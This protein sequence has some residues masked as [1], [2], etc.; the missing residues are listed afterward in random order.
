MTQQNCIICGKQLPE[1]KRLRG[2]RTCSRSCATKLAFSDP[3]VRQAHKEALNT[4]EAK[5]KMS[6][7]VKRAFNTGAREKL[8]EAMKK[9]WQ[10]QEY[11]SKTYNAIVKGCRTESARLH[12]SEASKRVWLNK[13]YHDK[14]VKDMNST[15]SKQKFVTAMKL[16]YET[17]CR[18]EDYK[19]KMSAGVRN[20]F[21][22]RKDE[23]I[24]K[25]YN[26]KKKNNSFSASKQEELSGIILKEIYGSQNVLRQYKDIRYPYNCDFYITTKD[27][28]IECNFFWHHGK[29]FFDPSIQWQKEQYIKW[30]EKSKTSACYKAA[31]YTW[32]KRDLDKLACAKRNNLNYLAFFSIKDFLSYFAY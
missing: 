20:A 9:K 19:L 25:Q 6:E 8:S 11:R 4:K 30:L 29:D 1:N 31:I 5:Q 28:F 2:T 21:A 10:D 13:E 3:K 26:T 18:N 27:L 32:T 24:Q 14:R 23:I 7:G 12:S 17:N 15:E 16:W 22:L